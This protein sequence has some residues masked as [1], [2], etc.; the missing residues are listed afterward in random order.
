MVE[1]HA[2]LYLTSALELL[3]AILA[4]SGAFGLVLEHAVCLPLKP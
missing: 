2:G 3:D 4:I 1:Q